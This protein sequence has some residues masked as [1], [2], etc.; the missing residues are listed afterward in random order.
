MLPVTEEEI[1][2]FLSQFETCT[3]PKEQWTHGAHVLT[4]ACYVHSLGERAAAGQMRR[5]VR[6][7]NVATGGQNTETS[8]YH[9]TVTLAW[10]KLLAGLLRDAQPME[11]AEF[12]KLALSRFENNR[13][14][15]ERYYEVDILSSTEARRQWVP[16][17]LAPLD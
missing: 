12:A 11:R 15:L 7:Y 16:P 2:C 3:L 4:G 5:C 9:E 17:T 10:I 13:K 6:R 8:G 14:I 1:D